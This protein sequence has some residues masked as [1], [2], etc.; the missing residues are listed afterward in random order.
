MERSLILVLIFAIIILGGLVI[1]F[2][3]KKSEEEIG[4]PPPP[5]K[6][7]FP[8]ISMQ[9]RMLQNKKI[10]LIIAF[11]DFRDEEYFIPK[12]AFEKA[13]AKIVTVSAFAGKATGVEGGEA[14]VNLLIDD[15][16][17][18]DFDAI[19]FIGGPGATIY[20]EDER[21]HSIAQEAQEKGKVLGAICIAPTIL[22]KAGV[23]DGKKATVW[24]G[25]LDKSPIKLLQ[26]QGAKYLDR[27]VVVDGKIITANGPAAAKEFAEKVVEA[28]TEEL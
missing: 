5:P 12:E 9:E 4:G 2:V 3:G 26:E 17:V 28:L 25:P 27:P 19:L 16:K 8:E 7:N 10:A 1:L 20:Q 23:L 6:V 11:R 22:A 14:E 18:D 24:S 15:L 13:G 21:A